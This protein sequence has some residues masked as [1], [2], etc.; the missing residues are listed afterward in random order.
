MVLTDLVEEMHDSREQYNRELRR[1]G[2]RLRVSDFL[3]LVD[4]AMEYIREEYGIYRH[5]AVPKGT[6]LSVPLLGHALELS[7]DPQTVIVHCDGVDVAHFSGA[8]AQTLYRHCF[9]AILTYRT[10]QEREIPF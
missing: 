10:T 6:A 2:R 1:I 3:P 5:D 4:A 8:E 7:L 9:E